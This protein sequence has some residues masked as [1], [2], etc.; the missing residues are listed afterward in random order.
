MT[1]DSRPPAATAK[2]GT[3]QHE[4]SSS[5]D[6]EATLTG[7]I[8]LA[9]LFSN[10]VEAFG[11]IH[12]SAK[13]EKTEQLLLCR[14]G[15]Q[16]ARLLIWGDVVG[17]SS[18]PASVTDRAVP[19]HPSAAYPDLKEPTFFGAR[20]ERL[21]DMETR[22]Q[23]ED[24]L[25]AIV[26]RQSGT[27]RE[28]MMEKY[29]LKPPKKFTPQ[30]EHAL[31]INRMEAFRERYELLQEVAEAYAHLST[32]RSSSITTSSWAIAD[33]GKFDG[34]IKLTQAKVDEL[35]VLMDVKEKVDRGMNMDIKSLGWHLS[36]DRQRIASDVSKLRLIAEACRD[37]YPEYIAATDTALKNIDRERRENVLNYNPYA[38]PNV[39]PVATTHAATQAPRRGSTGLIQ[40][41][42][43]PANGAGATNGAAAKQHGG[44]GGG[45]FFSSLFKSKKNKQPHPALAAPRSQSVSAA[46]SGLHPTTPTS[47]DP[48]RALSDAGPGPSDP[49]SHHATDPAAAP[50]S[51]TVQEVAP[52]PA[53]LAEGPASSNAEEDYAPPP[54]AIRSKSVGDIL[55]VAP[56]HQ[57]SIEDAALQQKLERLDTNATVPDDVV[58]GPVGGPVGGTSGLDLQGSVSRHDQFHGLGRQG[59]KVQW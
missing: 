36:A 31:D 10:C 27:T 9:N 18:P 41:S 32:R 13:W 40:A 59:T 47:Q 21:E 45:G 30:F 16:Q 52:Q 33:T 5:V 28:E 46:S 20:D 11:L 58:A 26:D 50:V 15:I 37:D 56:D 55:D 2:A 25:S 12:P 23:I 39:V 54:S 43:L 3:D 34:F 35:I 48:P 4:T 49:H 19:K 1:K 44:H 29:G 42:D 51:P 7:V 57:A 6:Y 22:K 17:V 24:A 38:D 53:P 8:A 14:L